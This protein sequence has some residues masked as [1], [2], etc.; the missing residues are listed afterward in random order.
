MGLVTFMGIAELAVDFTF[1]LTL[2]FTR[3]CPSRQSRR[4]VPWLT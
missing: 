4:E 2:Q 3:Q 1:L